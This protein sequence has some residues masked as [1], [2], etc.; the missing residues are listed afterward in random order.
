VLFYIET[1]SIA[2]DAGS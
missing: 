2:N 1:R